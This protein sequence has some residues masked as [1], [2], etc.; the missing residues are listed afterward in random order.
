MSYCDKGQIHCAYMAQASAFRAVINALMA[1]RRALRSLAAAYGM[2]GQVSRVRLCEL[3]KEHLRLECEARRACAAAG[4]EL[5]NND[6]PLEV[7]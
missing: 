7:I 3:G 6:K 1:E 2:S 5:R 4:I